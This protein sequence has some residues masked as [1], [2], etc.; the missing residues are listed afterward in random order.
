MSVKGFKKF[1]L[2]LCLILSFVF[3][4]GNAFF[5]KAMDV[6][7]ETV[8]LPDVRLKGYCDLYLDGSISYICNDPFGDRSIL[9][10]QDVK[11]ELASWSSER[12][13]WTQTGYS[14]ELVNGGKSAYI[15][16]EGI[17]KHNDK[18]RT[19]EKCITQ[20]FIFSLNNK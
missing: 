3:M 15:R 11:T 13:E 8:I 17:L 10:I 9:E 1:K 4:F 20:E 14:Y 18:K 6:Y 7:E 12:Y 16:L 2:L 5:V 19:W